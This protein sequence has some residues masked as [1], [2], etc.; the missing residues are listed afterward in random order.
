M[1]VYMD[2][3][4]V[5]V[6]RF[7]LRLLRYCHHASDDLLHHYHHRLQHHARVA[8]TLFLKEIGLSRQ[9]ADKFWSHQYSKKASTH[10]SCSHSW[11]NNGKKFGY[12]LDH[13]YGLTGGRKNYS[14]HSCVSI[15][16]RS[17]S[18]TE[19]LTC[20]FV[21]RDIDDL[22]GIVCASLK[23]NTKHLDN[24]LDLAKNG[25]GRKACGLLL[26]NKQQTL[27]SSDPGENMLERIKKPSHF[28]HL[29]EH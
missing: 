4:V 8:Y 6:D 1:S 22:T 13:L 21:T 7:L 9:E 11:Q 24:I 25:D 28:Y 5:V 26:K 3:V 19:Q 20:P 17:F 12:S 10:T 18:P 15:Q 27:P 16:D 23:D 29:L 14:A 2:V